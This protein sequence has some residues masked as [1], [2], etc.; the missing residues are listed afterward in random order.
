MAV[1]RL[2]EEIAVIGGVFAGVGCIVGVAAAVLT[3]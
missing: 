3:H 1:N 2:F